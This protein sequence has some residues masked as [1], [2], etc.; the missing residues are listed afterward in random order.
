MLK[1]KH[2][3]E[4]R[5]CDRFK[6]LA[7]GDEWFNPSGGSIGKVKSRSPPVRPSSHPTNLGLE[8]ENLQGTSIFGVKYVHGLR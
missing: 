2:V 5:R 4:S 8:N 3:S 7:P 1:A 6:P